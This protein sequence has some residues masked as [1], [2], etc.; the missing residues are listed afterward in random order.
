ML[1]LLLLLLYLFIY[2]FYLFLFIYLYLL[3]GDIQ[4]NLVPKILG[5]F[6]INYIVPKLLE[7]CGNYMGFTIVEAPITITYEIFLQI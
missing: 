6:K 7:S 3:F 2:S 5:T 1:L 4:W